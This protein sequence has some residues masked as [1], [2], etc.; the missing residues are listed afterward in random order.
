LL[1]AWLI[2]LFLWNFAGNAGDSLSYHRGR[3][4]STKDQDND[5]YAHSCATA[6]KGGWRYGKCASSSLNGFYYHGSTGK[7]GDGAYWA[8]WKAYDY[9]AKRAEMRIRHVNVSK[10]AKKGTDFC[11]FRLKWR[12]IFG[13]F[14]P[15]QG[16]VV[17]LIL[18]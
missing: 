2:L 8:T 11:R 12:K 13:R 9:S 4:F 6:H 14:Y 1:R 18:V 10:S 3:T 5:I 7:R 17:W 15:K 16:I